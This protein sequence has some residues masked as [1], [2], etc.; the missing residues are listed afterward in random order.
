M[1]DNT[2]MTALTG[3]LTSAGTQIA[4]LVVAAAGVLVAAA[5]IKGAGLRFVPSLVKGI[6]SRR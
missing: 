6:F 3:Y 5:A 4:T 2:T 1:I